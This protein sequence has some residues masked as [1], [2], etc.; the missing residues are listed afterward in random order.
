[1][2]LSGALSRRAFDGYLH[3][4]PRHPTRR[5]IFIVFQEPADDAAI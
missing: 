5:M 2:R 3:H 4:A 1:L